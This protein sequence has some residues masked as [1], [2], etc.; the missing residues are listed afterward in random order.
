MGA[1]SI[2]SVYE[3]YKAGDT[4]FKYYRKFKEAVYKDKKA[5]EM[6]KKCKSVDKKIDVL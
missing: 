2:G 6:V 3:M 5:L 4:F 1:L